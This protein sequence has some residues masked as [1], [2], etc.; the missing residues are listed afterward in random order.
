MAD[1]SVLTGGTGGVVTLTPG[2]AALAGKP[3]ATTK[4]FVQGIGDAATVRDQRLEDIGRERDRVSTPVPPQPI[5]EPKQTVTDPRKAWGSTA[6]IA[7]MLASAFTRTPMTTALNAAA[8]AMQSFH[9]NDI[10]QTKLAFDQWKVANENALKMTEF[11]QRTYEHLMSELDRRE[12]LT[13]QDYDSRVR[14]I[15]ADVRAQ[16]TAFRDNVMLETLNAKGIQGAAELQLKRDQLHLNQQRYA[17]QAETSTEMAIQAK[18]VQQS[19]EY[20]AADPVTRMH[21]LLPFSKPQFD[22]M[23]ASQRASLERGLRND[24]EKTPISK[25]FNELSLKMPVINAVEERMKTTGQVNAQD[26]TAL[27]DGFQRIYNNQAVRI[28]L[29]NLNTKHSPYMD[30]AAAVANGFDPNGNTMMAP[31]QAQL[32]LDIIHDYADNIPK[33]REKQFQMYT[34]IAEHAGVE[35]MDRP[36][37]E[38]G[39]SHEDRQAM[40]PPAP[41]QADPAH[42][43]GQFYGVPVQITSIYR[44][45]EKNDATPGASKTS[46]HLQAHPGEWA[47]DFKVPGQSMEQAAKTLGDGLKQQGYPF[48]QILIEPDHVH[49]GFGPKN[50]GEVVPYGG[51]KSVAAHMYKTK[52]DVAAAYHSGAI[53]REDAAAVLKKDF[54]VGG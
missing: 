14:S 21:M 25:A 24:F 17:L 18:E 40:G 52:E 19:P 31:H 44:G 29:V 6:M 50:R 7:T 38:A 22:Q 28:G 33:L 41:L 12:R 10:D 43:L 30:Q 37:A 11:Q 1:P 48:D 42:V 53:S 23:T 35:F 4:D 13:T 49:L 9:Q 8:K 46:E 54:N 26:A 34:D 45:K 47:V 51:K 36:T 39:W 27:V 16:A 32:L 3:D 2:A 15:T 20:Q 5:P